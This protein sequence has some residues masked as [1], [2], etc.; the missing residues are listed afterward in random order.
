MSEKPTPDMSVTSEADATLTTALRL[1][2]GA[3]DLLSAYYG[4]LRRR[5][6]DRKGGR[7]RDLVSRAD[8]EAERFLV[9]RIPET[10]DV[11]AEEGSVRSAGAARRWVVDPLDGTVNFLHGIPFWCV[12]IAVL[13][14]EQLRVGVVHAPALA[15]TFT[16]VAG[17]GCH[18]DGQPV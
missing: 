14:D 5:H 9:E 8:H 10:D 3:G 2:R 16:A 1:A 15:R 6:A 17:M 12:S 7:R 18:L 4:R 13:E 11:L